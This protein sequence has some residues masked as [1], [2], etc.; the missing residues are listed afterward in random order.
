[1]TA[2]LRVCAAP[3]CGT[4]VPSGYC[5]QHQHL[6]AEQRQ[7]TDARYGTQRWRRYSRERLAQHPWC[8]LCPELAK[9]TDHIVPVSE[10]PDRFWDESNHR[11]LCHACNRTAHVRH[12][13]GS[14][15]W[16]DHG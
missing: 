7:P 5:P 13:Q 1:M 15:V 14:K 12:Q 3:R 9:V 11:S 10:A 16:P 6:P 4:L 2:P 8:A